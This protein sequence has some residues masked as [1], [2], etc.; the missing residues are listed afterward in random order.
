MPC[1]QGIRLKYALESAVGSYPHDSMALSLPFGRRQSTCSLMQAEHGHVLVVAASH[2]IF[3]L[4]GNMISA[5]TCHL[6]TGG[7]TC[8]SP[9]TPARL[10]VIRQ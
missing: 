1:W 6:G 5:T 4:Q 3:R 9:R 7:F 8:G 2:L 10:H